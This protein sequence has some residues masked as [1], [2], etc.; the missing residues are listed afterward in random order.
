M[1]SKK[2]QPR[3]MSPQLKGGHLS[4]MHTVGSPAHGTQV[5]RAMQHGFEQEVAQRLAFVRWSRL[6]GYAEF[7]EQTHSGEVG[8]CS[9]PQTVGLDVGPGRS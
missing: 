2:L 8:S 5:N 7:S 4:G 3:A 9:G 1:D 6:E